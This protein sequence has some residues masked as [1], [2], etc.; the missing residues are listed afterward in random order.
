[1]TLRQK[2]LFVSREDPCQYDQILVQKRFQQAVYTG[3]KNDNIRVQ[4]REMLKHE[5]TSDEDLLD[6]LTLA[7][8]DES[9]HLEKFLPQRKSQVQ[10]SAV[11]GNESESEPKQKKANPILEELSEI[12]AQ[13]NQL[14]A[15]QGQQ[16]ERETHNGRDASHFRFQQDRSHSSNSRFR[17][18]RK[19]D[20]CKTENKD[21]CDHCFKCGASNHYSSGC[22][23]RKSTG[24]N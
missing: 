22:R 17:Y 3:L 10:V 15:D 21:G 23:V 16:K 14:F 12:R 8:T 19:C 7:V 9:E 20:Q 6:K 2:V 1:M 5:A 4:L 24:K 11:G 18:P 13:I